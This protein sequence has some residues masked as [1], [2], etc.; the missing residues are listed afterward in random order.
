MEDILVKCGKFSFLGKS[1]FCSDGVEVEVVLVGVVEFGGVLKKLES[2]YG[3]KKK[4]H[5][6]KLC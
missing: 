3:G 5:I 6:Q 4:S 2:C 1:S